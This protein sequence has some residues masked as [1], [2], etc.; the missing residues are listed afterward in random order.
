MATECSPKRQLGEIVQFSIKAIVDSDRSSVA[1]SSGLDILREFVPQA[2]ACS[3]TLSP[4]S[5]G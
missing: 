4:A 3:Y 2:V 5:A 1:R